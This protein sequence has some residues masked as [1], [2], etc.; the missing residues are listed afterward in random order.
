MSLSLYHMTDEY[1]RALADLTDS[2]LP[3]EAVA[4]TLEGLQGELSMKAA[5]VA[6]FALNLEAEAEAAKQAEDRI[7]RHRQT[8][9]SRA[10]QMRDYLLSNMTRA[11]IT[12][13]AA[14]DK[15][16]RVRVMAGRESCV[17]ES[18]E[19]LPSDYVRVKTVSEPDKTLI[20]KAIKEGFDV[21][22]ARLERKP[23]LKIG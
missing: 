5:N 17:I 23:S 18:E 2:D 10:K 20:T 11:G 1:R 13:I 15:S 6:A 9:E 4:D 21:P 14:L 16:F 22:G 7:K 12:E 19:A 8:L 3:P